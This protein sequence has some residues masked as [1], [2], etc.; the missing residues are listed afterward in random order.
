[1]MTADTTRQADGRFL[2]R[3]L[4]LLIMA[5]LASGAVAGISIARSDAG[6]AATVSQP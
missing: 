2:H 5:A 6:N 3:I 1:M 4:M